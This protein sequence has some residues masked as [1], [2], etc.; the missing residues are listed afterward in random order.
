MP[1]ILENVKTGVSAVDA[2]LAEG[3]PRSSFVMLSGEGGTGKSV[4]LSELLYRRLEAGEP[5]IYI[6]LD[7]LPDTVTRQ[8]LQFGWD[9]QKYLDAGKVKFIDCFSFRIKPNKVPKWVT[10]VNEPNDLMSFLT[11]LETTMDE[12]KM[13]NRGAVII[14]SLTEFMTIAEPGLLIEAIKTWRARGPKE[15][16]VIFFGSM[17]FG[18]GTLGRPTD[19]LDYIVDGIIDLHYNPFLMQQGQ[20][21]KELRVRKMKGVG[22]STEW[23]PFTVGETG[24]QILPQLRVK[25]LMGKEAEKLLKDVLKKMGEKEEPNDSH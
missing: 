22:H 13:R 20:L 19:V 4:L 18:I 5:C 15:R 16:G 3:M 25:R 12:L 14:D 2:A 11:A 6:C 1:V 9:L 24:I 8:M 23:I 7:D 10:L 21:V 17:H